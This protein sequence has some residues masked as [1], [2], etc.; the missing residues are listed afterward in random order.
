MPL[1][2]QN[3]VAS[4]YIALTLAAPLAAQSKRLWA[5]RAPGEITEY[6]PATFSA[7][8]TVKVPPEAVTSPQ[9]LSVN[10]LGQLLFAPAVS[11]PLEEDD[12]AADEK[13]WFWNASSATVLTR[14]ISRTTSSTG[15]NVAITESAPVPYLSADGTHLFWFANQARRLQREGV[16][17]S[18]KTTWQAWQT[19]LTGA[20]RQDLASMTLPDCPCPT[21]SCEETCPY[22][23]VSAPDEGIG[24]FFLLTQFIAGKTQPVYKATS[25][26]EEQNGKWQATKLDPPLHRMLDAPSS[27]AILEA[28]PD[29]AYCG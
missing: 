12:L 3:I 13:V 21:G 5:L 28:I 24:K 11:L 25:V 6:D 29:T 2:P 18:T 7:K 10:H 4:I 1:I 15:S 16:D 19:D 14:C 26:Y 20:G 22:G 8:Q 9:R 23:D 27:A 17:L